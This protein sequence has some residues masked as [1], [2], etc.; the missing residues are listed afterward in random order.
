[1]KARICVPRFTR[2]APIGL[3]S[4]SGSAERAAEGVE[5][6]APTASAGLV[7]PSR[8]EAQ[9]LPAGLGRALAAPHGPGA[10]L[11][12]ALRGGFER[13]LHADFTHVR[14]HADDEAHALNEALGSHAFTLGPDVFFRRGEYQ[15]HTP[16]G[17]GLL[18]HELTHVA[19]QAVAP[20]PA[21]VQ[22]KIYLGKEPRVPNDWRTRT[23]VFG[24]SRGSTV[25]FGAFN[26]APAVVD[27]NVARAPGGGGP[28]PAPALG[29]GPY[30]RSDQSD[31]SLLTRQ[32]A[33]DLAPE[34]DHIVPVDDGG[35]NSL[36]NA[37]V[38]SKRENNNDA[39]VDRP[40]PTDTA[41]TDLMAYQ[42]YRLTSVGSGRTFD[43]NAGRVLSLNAAQ[44]FVKWALDG[45][46]RSLADVDSEILRGI[47][48]RSPSGRASNRVKVQQR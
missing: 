33:T 13:R 16:A 25:A 29:A 45:N 6:H 18:A 10:E 40:D 2:P 11:A 36:Y 17:Q 14:V 32:L 46:L 19:Q 47:V 35:S 4:S 23:R 3:A 9:P 22:R 15:P 26:N 5:R 8:A 37:R 31:D 24:Y 42:N 7:A 38:L 30:P 44:L 43:V 1:V 21:L 27:D 48:K 39:L 41:E 34:V 28:I 12:P 20:G